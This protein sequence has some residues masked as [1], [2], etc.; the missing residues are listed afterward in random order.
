MKSTQ[1]HV[2]AAHA[3]GGCIMLA[4]DFGRPANLSEGTS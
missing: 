2:V 1:F 4:D 3:A